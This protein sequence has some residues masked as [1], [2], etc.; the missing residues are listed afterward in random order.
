MS[1]EK[2]EKSQVKLNF[3]VFPVCSIHPI[4][5]FNWIVHL[6]ICKNTNYLLLLWPATHTLMRR[7]IKNKC[8]LYRSHR[9]MWRNVNTNFNFYVRNFY[10]SE[11]DAISSFRFCTPVHPHAHTGTPSKLRV[12]LSC[13]CVGN[14]SPHWVNIATLQQLNAR[15]HYTSIVFIY[16]TDS[17]LNKTKQTKRKKNLKQNRITSSALHTVLCRAVRCLCNAAH[18]FSILKY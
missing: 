9:L 13:V 6:F 14:L 12:A 18:T 2:V 17:F 8:I 1:C 11:R 7:L 3:N 15:L 4:N 5:A 16:R 10:S